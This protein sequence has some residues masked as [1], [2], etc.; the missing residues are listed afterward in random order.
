MFKSKYDIKIILNKNNS[1]KTF[2]QRTNSHE[3]IYLVTFNFIVTSTSQTKVN[4]L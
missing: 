4:P 2:K 3:I 1:K